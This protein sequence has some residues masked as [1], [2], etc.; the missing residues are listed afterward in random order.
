MEDTTQI[1]Q[2]A[3]D[4]MRKKANFYFFSKVWFNFLLIGLGTLILCVF[5]SDIHTRS[6]LTKQEKNS[7]LALTAASDI[8]D[9]NLQS[10]DDL[11]KIYH[12]GNQIILDDIGLLFSN[13]L[14]DTLMSTDV[15]IRA[16]IF[17]NLADRIGVDYFFVMSMDGK[18]FISND[19]SLRD[20]NP[21]VPG[22]L[23]Q[24]NVNQLLH[25]TSLA[26]GSVQPVNVK[27]RFGTFYFYS[28]SFMYHTKRYALVIGSDATVIDDQLEVLKDIPSVLT[29]ISVINDGFIFAVDTDDNLFLHYKEG[30][31][32]LTGKST[33]S[34]GLSDNA[35]R[36]GYSG[37]ETILGN[38]YYCFTKAFGNGTVLCA[39]TR[40]SSLK[41]SRTYVLFWPVLGFVLVMI[42]CLTYAV[43][44]RNDFVRRAVKTKRIVLLKDS[45]NPYYFDRSIFTKVFPLIFAGV[46]AVF[47]ISFYTQTLVDISGGLAESDV[48]LQE[49]IGRYE[50]GQESSEVIE[51]YYNDRFLSTAKL[52]SF[53]LEEA[54]DVL[55]APS[56][57]YHSVIDENG[58]RQFLTDDEGNPLKS[59]SK[60]EPLQVLT[61]TNEINA[62]YL[63]DESGHV[64]ATSTQNWFFTLSRN[65]EDQSYPFRQVLNGEKDSYIQTLMTNELGE[66]A[67][68]FGVDWYYYTTKD[69]SGNTVYA[70][71]SAYEQ[72]S[73]QNSEFLSA[74]SGSGI[75]IHRSLLQIELDEDL[76]G[77]LLAPSSVDYILSTNMLDGGAIVLFDKDADH[78]CLYSP[79][80]ASIGRT[81]EDLGV[82]SKAFTGMDYYGFNNINGINYFQYFR[83]I[84]D[85]Y[86][87]TAIPKS[88][89]YVS[90]MPVSL[91]TAGAC[92]ILILIL[93]M[94]VAFTS[95]D[96]E[97]LYENMSE[98]QAEKVLNSPI[99]NIMLPSG[100]SAS[101]KRAASRWDNKH[102]RWS[103]KGP[104]QKL[105]AIL[106]VIFCALLVY[107]V[108]AALGLETSFN[109]NSVI[110]YIFSGSWDRNPN[111]FAF[112]AC[113]LVLIA[114]ILI[115]IGFRIPVRIITAF[116]GARGETV[117]RLLLS[118]VKYGCAIAGLFYCLFLL[119]VDAPSL[120]ASAGILSL[121]IG[122]GAQSLIRDILAGIFI[123]F[124]G[125][126]R[127]G[128]IVTISDF[129]GTVMD[130]G[131]R[132]TKIMGPTGNIKIYNNS[133]IS[134][135]L[136]MTKEASVATC[137]ISVEYGQDIDYVEAVLT[138]DL[139]LLQKK[140]PQ[141]LDGPTYAGVSNLGASGVD[142]LIF[143]K[144]YE[145]DI[146]GVTRYLNKE[147]LQIFYRNGINV[148]FPNVTVSQLDMTGRK[149]MDDFVPETA[150]GEELEEE[151]K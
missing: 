29:R 10:A 59:V 73:D 30:D 8:L 1:Q 90:R 113:A 69:E 62:I 23:T 117:G 89:M 118:I 135:V 140:N 26:D 44:V 120:L 83:Y 11:A 143:C 110:R 20:T 54:P 17:R 72:A 150:K 124:E 27:N 53:I 31:I 127:V 37:T 101:T 132:T 71:R 151:Q 40:T 34:A 25:F 35:L 114:V 42:I 144:C 86:F 99:F 74:E 5:L 129:R 3:S 146:K 80:R 88:G 58:T 98:E 149:T 119:G 21:A 94:T 32:L 93:I 123:V 109:D 49:V 95:K 48:A 24:D 134:G 82:S 141:I 115:T 108:L 61:E 133:D 105:S 100:R 14:F 128:D 85:Y 130:I 9:R 91:L 107:I 122:L 126:F 112:S 50:S 104:E 116:L 45:L 64:I 18:V 131:L 46:L 147:V 12:E 16:D 75:T 43:I 39:A 66:Y 22:Y 2:T 67:Q 6:A 84:D 28:K 19:D 41:A 65:E 121:V 77:K 55:N 78:I 57:Y 87:A 76:A 139:P 13:G 96:E 60:S 36:D 125:E 81:A 148:P 79:V 70:S 4:Q 92:F 63:Y 38:K 142:L 56:D 106:L 15:E 97:T 137:T 103:D 145:T 138:R 68:Y 52:L 102:I 47:G 51:N 111:I 136:N 7:R 33:S